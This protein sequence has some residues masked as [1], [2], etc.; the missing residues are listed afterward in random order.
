MFEE[1]I[2]IDG[3]DDEENGRKM[4]CEASLYPKRRD[5]PVVGGG[6]QAYYS[7]P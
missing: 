4:H 7:G 5:A 6:L 1:T 2:C 3:R